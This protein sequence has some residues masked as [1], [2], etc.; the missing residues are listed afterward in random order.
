MNVASIE[1]KMLLCLKQSMFD[2]LLFD[3]RKPASKHCADE[4]VALLC[5][6][7]QSGGH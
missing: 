5:H 4:T 7:H 1:Q 3:A 2:S 6:Y